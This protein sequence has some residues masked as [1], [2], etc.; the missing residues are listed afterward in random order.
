MLELDQNENDPGNLVT[1]F[2]K[3][4]FLSYSEGRDRGGDERLD[5]WIPRR[6]TENWNILQHKISGILSRVRVIEEYFLI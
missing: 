5:K 3:H 2:D 1:F 6:Y 4:I